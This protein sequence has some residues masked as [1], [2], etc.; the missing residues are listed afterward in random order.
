MNLE[1]RYYVKLCLHSSDINEKEQTIS[2]MIEDINKEQIEKIIDKK[3]KIL[4][5]TRVG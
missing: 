3:H 1:S 2:V 4:E 5:I